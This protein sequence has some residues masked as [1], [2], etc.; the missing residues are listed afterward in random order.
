MG[1]IEKVIDKKKRA[2]IGIFL[3]ILILFYRYYI[4]ETSIIR[5]DTGSFFMNR[6]NLW[7]K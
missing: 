4:K 7:S 1:S 6:S 5:A 3:F 2:R